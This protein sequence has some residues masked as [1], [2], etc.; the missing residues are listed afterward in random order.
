[1]ILIYI[2]GIGGNFQFIEF[3]T[4]ELADDYCIRIN[5]LPNLKA[6]LV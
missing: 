6:V 1:M 2:T 5:K 4:A 3:K